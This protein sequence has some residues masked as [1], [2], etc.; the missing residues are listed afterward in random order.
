MIPHFK[1]NTTLTTCDGDLVSSTIK[2]VHHRGIL[3][4]TDFETHYS[5][6]RQI[7]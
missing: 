2:I 6:E 4:F 7:I 3:L 5:E 1:T